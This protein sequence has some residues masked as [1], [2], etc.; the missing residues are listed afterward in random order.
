MSRKLEGFALPRPGG[1]REGGREGEGNGPVDLPHYEV[2]SLVTLG[3]DERPQKEERP[4]VKCLEELQAKK[5][6]IIL[7]VHTRD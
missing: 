4:Q 5:T 3:G 2:G 7:K 1:G 6:R